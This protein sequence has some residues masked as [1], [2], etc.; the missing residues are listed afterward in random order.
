M[1]GTRTPIVMRVQRL[2]RYSSACAV[3]YPDGRAHYEMTLGNGTSVYEGMLP[4]DSQN[5]LKSLLAA[6]AAIDPGSI[7]H[8]TRIDDVDMVL[9]SVAT[10]NGLHNLEF[11]DPSTR[12]PVKEAIDPVLRWLAGMNRQHLP[13]LKKAKATNCIPADAFEPG[14]GKTPARIAA[15][16]GRSMSEHM[17]MRISVFGA[18]EDALRERCVLVL[19]GGQYRYENTSVGEHDER[20]TRVYAGALDADEL[21]RLKEILDSPGIRNAEHKAEAPN[22]LPARD[23]ESIELTIPRDDQVQVLRMFSATG[24]GAAFT[25]VK[26]D[27]DLDARAMNPLR[28][29]IHT[30]IE[31]RKGVEPINNA[32]ANR[33][34]EY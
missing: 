5:Q 9:V 13:E 10:P 17:L 31:K 7:V 28:S 12:K 2:E 20:S 21:A 18:D 6:V 23:I 8:K 30:A 11:S 29:F 14:S 19:P 15:A 16:M 4:A 34:S 25:T 26:V 32:V 27:S 22:G 24:V 1:K 33:C 3:V